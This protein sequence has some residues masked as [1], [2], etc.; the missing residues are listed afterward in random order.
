MYCAAADAA[1][2]E[3]G[4]MAQKEKVNEASEPADSSES[5]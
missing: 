1:G 5:S 4:I 3:L 2:K